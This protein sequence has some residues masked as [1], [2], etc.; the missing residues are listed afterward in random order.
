VHRHVTGSTSTFFF[1]FFFFG[2]SV[3]FL[4]LFGFVD[5]DAERARGGA[6]HLAG[7]LGLALG[8]QICVDVLCASTIRMLLRMAGMKALT[9]SAVLGSSSSSV[10][11]TWA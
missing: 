8:A 1:F 6:L 9:A 2:A 3:V 7:Q 4:V 10:S 11:A 5:L